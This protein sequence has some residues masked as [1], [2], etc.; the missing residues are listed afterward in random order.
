[1]YPMCG[2]TPFDDSRAFYL[3]LFSQSIHSVP[4]LTLASHNLTGHIFYLTNC[5]M[6]AV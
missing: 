4:P 2:F 1:M 3:L 5:Q 6:K